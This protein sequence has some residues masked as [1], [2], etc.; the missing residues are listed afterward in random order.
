MARSND[1]KIRILHILQ[2]LQNETDEQQGL[3]REEIEQLLN[4]RGIT[5]GERKSFYRDIA[6]LKDCGYPVAKLPFRTP[7]YH[8]AQRSFS[9]FDLNLLVDAVQ[10]SQFITEQQSAE[11]IE[12]IQSLS[13]SHNRDRLAKRLAIKGRAKSSEEG[14]RANIDIIKDA[15]SLEPARKLQFT[16]FHPGFNGRKIYSCLED[17]TTP[18]VHLATPKEI[19]YRNDKY[20]LIAYVD[21]AQDFRTYRIDRIDT[22][23]ISE[24][25]AIPPRELPP[26][27]LND[28]LDNAFE[29]FCGK[30][31]SVD[32]QVSEKLVGAVLDQFGSNVKYLHNSL[33]SQDGR[34]LIQVKVEESPLFYAWVAKFEGDIR[35]VKPRQ[36]AQNYYDYLRS[37]LPT[38]DEA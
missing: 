8:L 12:K 28:H 33:D 2:I 5:P 10:N 16:Y 19:V 20:Y 9:F 14:A 34:G 24:E 1:Q 15:S 17:G 26:Y 7:R 30:R 32:L 22:L 3:T 11:L 37:L 21:H 25:E 23:S 31:V 27:N 13:P 29:M 35:I 18:L 38:E 6:T 36:V 4:D